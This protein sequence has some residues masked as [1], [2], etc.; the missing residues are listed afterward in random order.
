MSVYHIL[1]VPHISLASVLDSFLP[2]DQREDSSGACSAEPKM[3]RLE[4]LKIY[5]LLTSEPPTEIPDNVK[6]P[7]ILTFSNEEVLINTFMET[8]N[9]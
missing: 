1:S 6:T 3:E 7:V 9:I 2:S 4:Y 5:D 8:F